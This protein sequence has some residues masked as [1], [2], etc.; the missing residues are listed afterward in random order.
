M[1][2]VGVALENPKWE[3]IMGNIAG[4]RESMEHSVC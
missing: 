1:F 2:L 4:E 3:R